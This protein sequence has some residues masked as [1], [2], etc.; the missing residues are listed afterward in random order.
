M[1]DYVAVPFTIGTSSST[2]ELDRVSEH[3]VKIGAF[4]TPHSPSDAGRFNFGAC[5]IVNRNE[6]DAIVS[7]LRG[8]ALKT[9]NDWF[10]TGGH[11][12]NSPD[13]DWSNGGAKISAIELD[14]AFARA[15]ELPF[16]LADRQG[17]VWQARLQSTPELARKEYER[18]DIYIARLKVQHEMVLGPNRESV[19]GI[20]PTIDKLPRAGETEQAWA[21]RV[22]ADGQKILEELDLLDDLNWNLDLYAAFNP[23]EDETEFRWVVPGL[24]PRGTTTLV[25]GPSG[26]GKSTMLGE[27]CAMIGSQSKGELSFLGQPVEGGGSYMV[28]SGEENAATLSERQNHFS[29]PEHGS[30]RRCLLLPAA[31]K[32]IDEC[33]EWPDRVRWPVDLVIADPALKFLR[34]ENSP[35]AVSE[36]YDKLNEVAR[37]HNCA[38]ILVHHLRKGHV[39][40]FAQMRDAIR[41]SSAF[42]DRP[43]MVIGMHPRGADLVDIGILK[44]NIPP[45]QQLWGEP[46]KARL[47]RQNRETL[48]LDRVDGPVSASTATPGQDQQNS[49]ELERWVLDTVRASRT[50]GWEVRKT[51]RKSLYQG[52]PATGGAYSRQAIE[53]AQ[54]ALIAAG[55]LLDTEH[56]LKIADPAPVD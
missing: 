26:V 47:F 11:I 38:V 27:L 33:L 49:A 51:G 39:Q 4:H 32:D 12:W 53:R 50:K 3:F 36:L 14:H 31:G 22:R 37:R 42:V 1:S 8:T 5:F 23:S 44:Q 2:P 54:E 40:R 30:Y 45:S 24:I 18:E 25:I 35:E 46:G 41:G 20:E 16:A 56:G 29:G 10:W 19:Q 9:D 55:R 15:V 13:G 17:D 7:H 28:F 52:Q 6:A 48:R 43:R 21:E 34:D